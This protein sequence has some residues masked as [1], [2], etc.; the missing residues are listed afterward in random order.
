MAT[1]ATLKPYP[2]LLHYVLP[3][4]GR[5]VIAL[6]ASAVV[7]L[8]DA[9]Y[10][11][12]IRPLVDRVILG[13]FTAGVYLV[14]VVVITMALF[15]GGARFAQEYFIRTAGQL[16][17]QILRNDVYAHI[18]NLSMHFMS[19]ASSGHL[20]SR[21]LNDI[22]M[23]QR[24]VSTVLVDVLRQGISLIALIGVAFYQDWKLASAAFLVIPFSVLPAAVIG[25]KI[26][27]YTVRGQKRMGNLTGVLQESFAGFKVIK[28]FGQEGEGNE[29]FQRENRSYY[30]LFRKT[31]KYESLSSPIVETLSAFGMATVLA[32]GL[33]RVLS[34]AVTEGQL[35]SSLAAMA[36]MYTPVKKLI[37]IYNTIQKAMGAAERVFEVLD[38]R[39]EIHDRPDACPL[40]EPVRGEV[41]FDHVFFAYD[42]KPVLNDI[43]IRAGQGEVIAL[44]G[45]SGSGKTTL[46][47][48][49]NRFFDPTSGVV[50]VDGLD[51]SRVTLESLKRN[52]ALVDQETFLFNDTVRSNIRFGN[53]AARED[54]IEAATRL[55][56]AEEF[57]RALPQ[58]Y[59]TLIG[60]RGVLLSGGQRQRL[61]IARALVRNAPILVL[62]EATSALDTESEA[63]VQEALSNL[64]KNRTTFIIAHRLST[65]MHA[66]RILVLDAGK[67]VEQGSHKQLLAQKGLYYRLYEMQ[68]NA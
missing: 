55:A 30:E 45:P 49:L 14:P 43:S 33:Q 10:A 56:Y 52:L 54:E 62:D 5:L 7:G 41:E 60:D 58:G 39:P 51:I 44:V 17:I 6:A 40:P 23:M 53:P 67:V 57:V 59:E 48:L 35:F 37:G 21:V 18:M 8:T 19:G 46:V 47:G 61:C 63:L 3:F 15:K 50:R 27:N 25:K 66:D 1:T 22:G 11:G 20:M 28:A 29:R 65:V 13:G 12:L 68:F 32:Y 64:M 31:L 38:E 16:S 34:G 4:K 24:A 9:G 42:E 36:M 26:K 2:R